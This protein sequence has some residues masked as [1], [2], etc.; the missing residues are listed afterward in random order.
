MEIGKA[1]YQQEMKQDCI[2]WQL[3]LKENK[4]TVTD[5]Y[6]VFN[7]FNDKPMSLIGFR[8]ALE[9]GTFR[10]DAYIQAKETFSYL[11]TEINKQPKIYLLANSQ[12]KYLQ[13]LGGNDYAYTTEIKGAMI[14]RDKKDAEKKNQQLQNYKCKI[15][16]WKI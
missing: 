2:L 5:A 10:Y 3:F 12:G 9:S 7:S 14:F 6:N 13:S 8:K 11:E 16:Q 1:I 15:E 4:I